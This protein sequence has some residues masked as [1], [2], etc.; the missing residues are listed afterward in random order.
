[1]N[2]KYTCSVK[3][4]SNDLVNQENTVIGSSTFVCLIPFKGFFAEQ[5]TKA[6]SFITQ[7]NPEI[8]PRTQLWF[9]LPDG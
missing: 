2:L 6:S 9:H 3:E 7:L 1:V 8:M 5:C 4:S